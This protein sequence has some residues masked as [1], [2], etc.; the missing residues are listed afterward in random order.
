[1]DEG[2]GALKMAISFA[3]TRLFVR[4]ALSAIQIAQVISTAGPS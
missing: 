1:M 2:L 3:E 4:N